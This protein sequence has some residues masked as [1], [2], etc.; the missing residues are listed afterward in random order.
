[1]SDSRRKKKDKVVIGLDISLPRKDRPTR[2]SIFDF[3]F[4]IFEIKFTF[5]ILLSCYLLLGA[6]CVYHGTTTALRKKY[7]LSLST[8]YRELPEFLP[9][10]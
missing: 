7:L 5:L 4:S 8:E 3:R 10:K 9:N 6:F 1:M 2:F